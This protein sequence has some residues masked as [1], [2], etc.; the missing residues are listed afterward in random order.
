MWAA[1]LAARAYQGITEVS[2]PNQKICC[3]NITRISTEISPVASFNLL[4]CRISF[5]P[6]T[7]LLW[8]LLPPVHNFGLQ[9]NLGRCSPTHFPVLAATSYKT[10]R[11]HKQETF[12]QQLSNLAALKCMF[13]CM[14]YENCSECSDT[15]C[16]KTL[17]KTRKAW[18]C[19]YHLKLL[20][21]RWPPCLLLAGLKTDW[22]Y[23]RHGEAGVRW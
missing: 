3:W 18:N 20:L 1:V 6:A 5:S 19:K 4:L 8:I 10:W 23:R 9:R 15:V 16:H 12:M 7:S 14:T 17:I 13:S 21:A 2:V 11:K 22:K